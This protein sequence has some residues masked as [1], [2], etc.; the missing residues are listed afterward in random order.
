MSSQQICTVRQCLLDGHGK[1]SSCRHR[2]VVL[3]RGCLKIIRV[4]AG[5]ETGEDNNRCIRVLFPKSQLMGL[6]NRYVRLRTEQ[7][8]VKSRGN[9]N[10]VLPNLSWF[11]VSV[12]RL[13]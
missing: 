8:G 4:E 13:I 3:F 11:W 9:E 10:E 12:M 2:F 1:L 7:T 6:Y 5:D